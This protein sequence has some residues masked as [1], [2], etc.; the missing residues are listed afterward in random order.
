MTVRVLAWAVGASLGLLLATNCSSSGDEAG[1]GDDD[2]DARSA[3]AGGD[4]SSVVLTES[5]TGVTPAQ[6]T[7]DGLE[8]ISSEQAEAIE[9]PERACAGWSA[10]PEGG[11]PP[12]LEFVIDV[13]GSMADQ[14]AYPNDPNNPA[15]KW[16]EMQRVLPGVFDSLPA[17]WAVGVSFYRKPDNDC[18]LPDQSVPID[19]MTDAQKSL[20]TQAIEVRGPKPSTNDPDNV[21]GATPT[22]AAWRFGVSELTAWAAPAGYAASP[23]Y[24]V[25]I[26]D[27]VPTVNSDGCTY[28]NPVTQA[29]YDQE[30]EIVRTEGEAANVQTFVV[31]V[32]GSEQTGNATYDPLYMLSQLAVAGGTEE[33][34]G[35][36]PVSGVVDTSV[37]PTVLTS[38]G[39]YC[40]YDLSTSTDF[41]GSLEMALL[42]IANTVV[43]CN[44][45]V[46][47]PPD[48]AQVVDPSLTNLVYRDGTTA[49][50][51]VLPNTSDNCDRGW[52]FT[53][54]TNTEL[55]ICG[56]TCDLI[57]SNF[58]ARLSVV[59]GCRAGELPVY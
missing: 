27:G 47:P 34:A 19:L 54:S 14:P 42:Q 43:S 25:L 49:N 1:S 59:F 56:V 36:T 38:R 3:D 40:H 8:V 28:V 57:Q 11:L 5:G 53:D 6:D 37:E 58:A 24:T 35:C 41:A 30:V 52:H 13:T 44:Y 29:E 7:V 17:S 2:D 9:D 21:Q 16:Q 55:E 48:S 39:S 46:P 4:G 31:G 50:Y 32:L 45:V 33:P 20:I 18:F 22:L 26:T 15:S 23:R 10:E 51:L 12:I